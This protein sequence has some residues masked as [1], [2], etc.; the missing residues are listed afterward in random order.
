M[1]FQNQA[2]II[3]DIGGGSTELILADSQE[4]RF[5]GSTKIGAGAF[6]CKIRLPPIPLVPQN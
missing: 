4:I 2:H 1:D 6:D 5:L 3:I